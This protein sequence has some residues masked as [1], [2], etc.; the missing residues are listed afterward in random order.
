MEG[1]ENICRVYNKALF[2]LTSKKSKTF[3]KKEKKNFV[4]T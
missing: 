4:P 2:E 3:K 1:K